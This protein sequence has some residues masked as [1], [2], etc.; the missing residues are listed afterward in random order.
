MVSITIIIKILFLGMLVSDFWNECKTFFK[1]E[2]L[3]D[4]TTNYILSLFEQLKPTY[5]FGYLNEPAYMKGDAKQLVIFGKM[6]ASEAVDPKD[7]QLRVYCAD[8]NTR[9]SVLLENCP[10]ALNENSSTA[11][12]IIGSFGRKGVIQAELAKIMHCDPKSVFH[13]LLPLVRA[14]L[15][16]RTPVAVKSFSYQLMLSRLEDDD[17]TTTTNVLSDNVTVKDIRQRIIDKLAEA[18]NQSLPSLN[19][20]SACGIPRSRIPTWKSAVSDLLTNGWIEAYMETSFLKDIRVFRL[21]KKGDFAANDGVSSE[22]RLKFEPEFD[23]SVPFYNQF[24][25][26]VAKAFPDGVTAHEICSRLCVSKKYFYRFVDAVFNPEHE[27]LVKIADFVGK[28]KQLK[29]YVKDADWQRKYLQFLSNSPVEFT[30]SPISTPLPSHVASLISSR[31][32]SPLSTASSTAS[33][34]RHLRHEIIL[35]EL[36]EK[37]ILEV[38]TDL[39]RRI[40]DQLED[41]KHKLDVKTLRRSIDILASEG[42]LVQFVVSLPSKH[43]GEVARTLA[44]LPDM[45]PNCQEVIDY[46][47]ALREGQANTKTTASTKSHLSK[48]SEVIL[49]NPDMFEP[50]DGQSITEL[51]DDDEHMIKNRNYGRL[52]LKQFGLLNGIMLRVQILHNYLLPF[53]DKTVSLDDILQVLKFG[54]FL[55]IIGM[56]AMTKTLYSRANELKN[57]CISELPIEFR[58]ELMWSRKRIIRS[59]T[60]LMDILCQLSLVDR[61]YLIHSSATFNGQS[62]EFTRDFDRYWQALRASTANFHQQITSIYESETPSIMLLIQHPDSWRRT[63]KTERSLERELQ[64]LASKM[65]SLE[66][67]QE[68]RKNTVQPLENVDEIINFEINRLAE[69]YDETKERLLSRL[70][71]LDS[72]AQ[73]STT[74]DNTKPKRPILTTPTKESATIS[75]FTEEEC[76]KIELAFCVQNHP[77]FYSHLGYNWVTI[78]QACGFYSRYQAIRSYVTYYFR[79]YSS[80]LQM[81]ELDSIAQLVMRP[82]MTFEECF[83]RCW[84]ILQDQSGDSLTNLL[85]EFD[86]QLLK[87]RIEHYWSLS[88]TFKKNR[89]TQ[90]D[91][92]RHQTGLKETMTCFVKPLSPLS[93]AIRKFLVW[94]LFDDFDRSEGQKYLQ[95]VEGSND[96][97]TVKTAIEELIDVGFA[98]KSGSSLRLFGLPFSLSYEL[99]EL[100]TRSEDEFFHE[101]GHDYKRCKLLSDT[102]TVISPS[103]NYPSIQGYP[104][105]SIKD[106]L[107]MNLEIST[108]GH[109][110]VNPIIEQDTNENINFSPLMSESSAF[111]ID[112]RGNLLEPVVRRCL[113]L[114][115]KDIHSTPGISLAQ[116]HKR[117]AFI[118]S[119]E[120]TALLSFL[121]QSRRISE[122]QS[123]YYE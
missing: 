8:P 38:S 12:Q 10:I 20:F 49:S 77:K 51:D 105:E 122:P 4:T 110:K 79:S 87:D 7:P 48:L 14:D 30:P 74:K 6:T 17:L 42:R 83:N 120:L 90:L 93:L 24:V 65:A 78:A 43:S 107:N 57:V 55:K 39:V 118:S 28:E 82:E 113:N 81:V 45:T 53:L 26:L 44:I 114:I 109:I 99:K 85:F 11:L 37:R 22:P 66:R 18:P 121:M 94:A 115:E 34:A 80:L 19:L 67:S 88:I 3:N 92:W 56:T 41:Q 73:K 59:L 32:S 16:S 52:G 15:I 64:R 97:E 96:E 9:L 102:L 91:Y 33:L 63:F 101:F 2:A 111:W 25:L 69:E 50:V 104:Y 1:L 119:A 62:Y 29:F 89:S 54:D 117:H 98:T 61:Q 116:L 76:S 35:Q 23:T 46:I 13:W 103:T 36:A 75:L 47:S 68:R 112:C 84:S 95:A 123:G 100:F 27:G 86:S 58:D 71:L 40:Q 72:R 5:N 60:V 21:L 70:Q 31:P 108:L 106:L